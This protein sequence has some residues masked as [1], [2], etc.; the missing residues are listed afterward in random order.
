MLQRADLFFELAPHIVADIGFEDE[1]VERLKEVAGLYCRFRQCHAVDRQG[2]LLVALREMKWDAAICARAVKVMEAG[3][4]GAEDPK[5]QMAV[6]NA[7]DTL[8]SAAFDL[9]LPVSSWHRQVSV[10]AKVEAGKYV[11]IVSVSKA[12]RRLRALHQS[13]DN[14][15][16]ALVC[17]AFTDAKEMRSP[18]S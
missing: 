12:L 3:S 10:S 8:P 18:A 1:E 11:G 4:A 5:Y 17:V 2:S 7:K 14:T 6:R 9:I 16:S 13:E 15:S